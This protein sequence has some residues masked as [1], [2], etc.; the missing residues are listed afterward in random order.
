MS[1]FLLQIIVDPEPGR[2]EEEELGTA[3]GGT[4]RPELAVITFEPRLIE[5]VLHWM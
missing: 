4:Y 2:I 5:R 1:H 3:G